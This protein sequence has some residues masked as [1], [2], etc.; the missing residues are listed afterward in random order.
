[1]DLETYAGKVIVFKFHAEWCGPC[2]VLAPIASKVSTATGVEIVDIDI[3]TQAA[4][5]AMMGVRSVPT[6]IAW[7]GKAV[8]GTLTGNRPELAVL[9]FFNNLKDAVEV[10]Q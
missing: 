3:D 5:T 2:K 6:M 8:V 9:D 4:F 1:M 10:E 7:T